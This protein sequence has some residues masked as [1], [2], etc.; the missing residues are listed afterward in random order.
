MRIIITCFGSV[1]IKCDHAGKCESHLHVLAPLNDNSGLTQDYSDVICRV[2]KSASHR[3][4]DVMLS[5][6]LDRDQQR[7]Q[8]FWIID[9][10]NRRLH[11]TRNCEKPL[12]RLDFCTA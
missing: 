7:P 11:S 1:V 6:L 5:Y 4:Q 3:G 2:T 12:V 8:V 10:T 9:Y